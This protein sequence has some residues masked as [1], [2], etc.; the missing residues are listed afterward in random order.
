[1]SNNIIFFKKINAMISII[2]SEINSMEF[3]LWTFNSFLVSKEL[4]PPQSIYFYLNLLIN[5]LKTT[6]KLLIGFKLTLNHSSW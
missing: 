3:F 2:V 5:Q 4:Y 1:M 6:R